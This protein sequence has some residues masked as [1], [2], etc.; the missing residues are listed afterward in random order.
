MRLARP[1]LPIRTTLVWVCDEGQTEQVLDLRAVDLFGPAP[2]EVIED[3]STGKRAF[4]MRRSM[5]RFS[6]MVASPSTSCSR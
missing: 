4:L 6:S 3:L 2:L 1:T 5:L